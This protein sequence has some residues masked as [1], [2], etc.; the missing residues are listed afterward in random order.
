LREPPS[1][2]YD[3]ADAG[4]GM[5]KVVVAAGAALTLAGGTLLGVAGAAS[6]GTLSL[7]VDANRY[8][9]PTPLRVKFSADT[10]PPLRAKFFAG[11]SQA[12]G[13]VHYQWCFDDGT[14]SREQNPRHSFR[15]AGYYNV[16]VRVQE[17]SGDQGRKTLLLGVWPPRQWGAAQKKAPTKKEA[18]RA[19]RVQQ[20]RTR[21][22]RRQLQRRDGLTREKCTSQP[23]W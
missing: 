13:P 7:F 19:G 14:Q 4:A 23:L 8:A 1:L 6:Q 21:K 15:R 12:E 5:R 18:R 17:E 22:R 9:G 10:S 16:T 2:F 3:R 11:T 20:Q